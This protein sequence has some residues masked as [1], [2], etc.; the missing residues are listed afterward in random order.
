[1]QDGYYGSD[2]LISLNGIANNDPD[3]RANGGPDF[4][5]GYNDYIYGFAGNDYLFGGVGDD[6]I[7]GGQGNDVAIFLGTFADY[8]IT[9]NNDGTY[10][11]SDHAKDYCL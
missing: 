11:V 7:D 4:Y 8:T 10:I 2:A 6:Y 3:I 9:D 1:M 5:T